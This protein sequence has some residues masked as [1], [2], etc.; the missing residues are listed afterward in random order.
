MAQHGTTEPLMQASV[1]LNIPPFIPSNTK[2]WFLQLQAVFACRKITSQAIKFSK[3][4]ENL[5][6][7]MIDDIADLLD[8]IPAENPY[9]TLKN[10]I[11]KRTGRSDEQMLKDFFNNTHMG[12][13]TPSQLLRYMKQQLGNNTMSEPVLRRL[14][15]DKLPTTMAQ[16]LA[17]FSDDADLEKLANMADKIHNGYNP[18]IQAITHPHL[19]QTLTDNN[20]RQSSLQTEIADIK[21][22]LQFLTA[23]L[24]QTRISSRPMER[25]NYRRDQSQSREK[26]NKS[27]THRLNQDFCWYH[28]TFG[29][30]ARKCSEPCFFKTKSLGNDHTSQ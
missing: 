15:V 11:I 12:D 25:N 20:N 5:P 10:A 30:K 7:D 22:Q 27:Q 16:I 19:T 24:R 18:K 3:V 28:Q 17:P 8:P 26:F 9:D 23:Q 13:R 14:W 1:H 29:Q 6:A 21:E 2:N 4:V